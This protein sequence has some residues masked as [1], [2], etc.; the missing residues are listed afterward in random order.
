MNSNNVEDE[1]TTEENVNARYP[2][3]KSAVLDHQ[4]YSYAL[5]HE[6]QNCLQVHRHHIQDMTQPQELQ[7]LCKKA[8]CFNDN[9]DRLAV[10]RTQTPRPS[11]L[12]QNAT[13]TPEHNVGKLF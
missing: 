6:Y 4:K 12:L 2:T 1:E 9:D 13:K 7:E 8:P 5:Q 3:V 11:T 10:A